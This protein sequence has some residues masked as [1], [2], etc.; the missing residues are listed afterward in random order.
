MAESYIPTGSSTAY[1]VPELTD[2][3][4]APQAFRDFA[5]SVQNVADTLTVADVA[6][7]MT[8]AA[9]DDCT[10]L[11]VDTALAAADVTVT[12]PDNATVPLP[13]GFTVAVANLGG[14]GFKVKLAK[15]PGVVIQDQ[16]FLSVED[17]RITTLVKV[18]TDS[19]LVQAGSAT[20]TPP[21]GPQ[22][23]VISSPAPTGQYTDVDWTW[24]YYTFTGSGTLTVDTEGLIEALIVGGGGGSGPVRNGGYAHGGGGSCAA[25]YV[26]ADLSAGSYTVVV[27]GGGGGGT[28]AGDPYSHGH[29]G[30]VSRIGDDLACGGGRGGAGSS[31]QQGEGASWSGRT[32]R[33]SSITGTAVDY[34][35][36]GTGGG[37][38]GGA[39]NTGNGANGPD[40]PPNGTPNLNGAAGGSGIVIVRVRT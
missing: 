28:G 18:T 40:T 31:G 20:Y 2:P 22:P 39:A 17:Y 10:M 26:K 9:S 16:G 36:G 7:N 34:G 25:T 21:S 8:L 4:D 15:G 6:A 19:W 27:G 12:V 14:G 11:S 32:A 5:D 24:N 23:A 35:L 33:S 37:A 1:T 3:A 13:V 38:S 29:G 30:Q